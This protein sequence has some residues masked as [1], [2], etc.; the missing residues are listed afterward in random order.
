MRFVEQAKLLSI[1]VFAYSKRAGTPA[2]I[3]PNQVP[4][5]IKRVRSTSL[6]KKQEEIKRS[7][8]QNMI[9]NFPIANVLFETYDGTHAYGHTDSFV[10]VKVP[11]ASPPPEDIVPVRLCCT[12]GEICKGILI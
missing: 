5:D 8:L 1:H 11:M 4:E 9:T 6:I 10:E 12:D 7:V 3:M 2:A